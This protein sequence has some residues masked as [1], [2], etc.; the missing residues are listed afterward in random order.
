M[1]VGSIF[2]LLAFCVLVLLF[3][4]RPFFESRNSSAYASS[5]DASTS[6]AHALSAALA[7]RDRILNTLYE[8]DFDHDMGKIPEGD[9]QQQRTLL[10]EEGA[11]T[12]KKL[13]ELQ[14]HSS[15]T[16][17]ELQIEYQLSSWI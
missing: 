1:G 2:L 13:D 3:I 6:D 9:Y 16:D 11:L 7:E 14:T 5:S 12:L 15:G 8:L 10:L 4:S 17:A